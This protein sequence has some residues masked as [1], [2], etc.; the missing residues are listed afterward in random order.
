MDDPWGMLLRLLGGGLDIPN[1]RDGL[2][3]S[4]VGALTTPT[5]PELMTQSYFDILGTVAWFGLPLI[6]IELV[7]RLYQALNNTSVS[8]ELRQF[9]I[10]ALSLFGAIPALPAV[11]LGVKGFFDGVG[12]W[13]LGIVAGTTDPAQVLDHLQVLTGNPAFD[14][15]LGP[16]QGVFLFVLFLELFVVTAMV[17]AAA[18][19]LTLGVIF[20]WVGDFGRALFRFSLSFALYGTAANLIMLVIFGISFGVQATPVGQS[21]L[22]KAFL[23]TAAMIACTFV[24]PRALSR[25]KGSFSGV[26][27]A[28]SST[29][30][31]LRR[32]PDDNGGTRYSD[33]PDD[34]AGTPGRRGR[35]SDAEMPRV[36]GSSRQPTA[37]SRQAKNGESEATGEQPEAPRRQRTAS[38]AARSR[39]TDSE[40]QPASKGGQATSSNPQGETAEP[41]A[42]TAA[43]AEQSQHASRAHGSS[44]RSA[45]R[46]EPQDAQDNR[47]QSSRG[48]TQ[49]QER[50]SAEPSRG[51][52]IVA[53]AATVGAAAATAAGHPWIGA[54]VGLTGAAVSSRSA[55]KAQQRD[56]ERPTA[57][58]APPPRRSATPT[59][60]K[61][62]E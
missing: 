7:Y 43:S 21:A 23:N 32:K 54:G 12:A 11:V 4:V 17:W 60:P 27:Q 53:G 9:G 48:S 51:A 62:G 24:V 52:S 1:P 31:R 44:P 37:S 40:E 5:Q 34:G 36:G 26:V 10:S 30:E 39:G 13:L 2:L 49:G 57:S 29:Y 55:T 20:R 22:A 16:I 28:A 59:T 46:P 61:G 25:L 33:T 18:L 45:S 15:F 14:V 58:E 41:K 56:E 8:E 50:S 6:A 35:Q 38:S 3:T 19:I 47:P 42:Q